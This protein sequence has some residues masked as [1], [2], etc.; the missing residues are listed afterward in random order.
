[1]KLVFAAVCELKHMNMNMNM[2]MMDRGSCSLCFL[3]GEMLLLKRAHTETLP[4]ACVCV[5][6]C[7]CV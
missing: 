5:C 2:M 3:S 7:V 4:Q 1:M 6:V